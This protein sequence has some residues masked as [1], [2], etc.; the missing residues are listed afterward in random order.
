MKLWQEEDNRGATEEQD[1]ADSEQVAF[2]GI[3]VVPDF[4][5][6]KLEDEA[7]ERNVQDCHDDDPDKSDEEALGNGFRVYPRKE[8]PREEEKDAYSEEEAEPFAFPSFPAFA[9]N[10]GRG[11]CHSQP[12]RPR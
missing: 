10:T 4:L 6:R 5:P 8:K 3:K 12:H 7:P 2:R 9:A 11:Y 1:H